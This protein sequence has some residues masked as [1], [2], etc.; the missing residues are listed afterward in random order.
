MTLYD[1]PPAKLRPADVS[2]NDFL[3]ALRT[4][5]P[6]VNPGELERYEQWTKDFG[7]DG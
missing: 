3:K 5:R 7:Q 1:V 4:T 2:F 6:S